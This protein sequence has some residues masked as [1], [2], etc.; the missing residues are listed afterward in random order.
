RSSKPCA[1]CWSITGFVPS[2]AGAKLGEGTK[3][4][5][6]RNPKSH[7]RTIGTSSGCL[8]ENSNPKAT[9]RQ[10]LNKAFAHAL[11][12]GA[13][14]H[15]HGSMFKVCFHTFNPATCLILVTTLSSKN[16]DGMIPYTEISPSEALTSSSARDKSGHKTN[17]ARTRAARAKSRKACFEGGVIW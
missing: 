10:F 1:N 6:S 4:S 12:S 5:E 16:Q 17:A 8:H 14:T 3:G 15:V 2:N 9:Q 11:F 7:R 13:K